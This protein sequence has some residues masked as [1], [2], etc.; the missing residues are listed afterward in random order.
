MKDLKS[1]YQADTLEQAEQALEVLDQKR[2]KLYSIS[3]NSRKN[4]RADLSTYFVYPRS[5]RKLMYTTNTIEA[6]NRQLRK[7]TKTTTVF[8]TENA[9]LKLIYLATLNAQKKRYKPIF[10]R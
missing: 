9:L 6:F 7:V 3:V 2:G 8:P 5:I 4:N 10:N 1:I